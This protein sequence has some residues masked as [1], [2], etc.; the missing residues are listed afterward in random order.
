M[1]AIYGTSLLVAGILAATAP[2]SPQA[3]THACHAGKPYPRVYDKRRLFVA[4]QNDYVYIYTSKYV[5]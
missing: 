4:A 2:L 3:C 1:L 5:F